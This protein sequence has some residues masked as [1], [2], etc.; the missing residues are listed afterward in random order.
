MGLY[1]GHRVSPVFMLLLQS[2]IYAS[3]HLVRC[4][5]D[6]VFPEFGLLLHLFDAMNIF[7]IHIR[8]HVKV[9]WKCGVIRCFVNVRMDGRRRDGDKGVGGGVGRRGVVNRVMVAE[10]KSYAR[11]KGYRN[12]EKALT[13]EA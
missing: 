10:G 11:G 12:T 13:Q 8:P 5:M 2:H 3:K 9:T 1:V 4:P 6:F 7:E